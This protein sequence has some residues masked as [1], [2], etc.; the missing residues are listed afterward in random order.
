MKRNKY[1]SCCKEFKTLDQFHHNKSKKDGFTP[2]CKKC[3]GE[4]SKKWSDKNKDLKRKNNKK[5][6]LRNKEEV[7]NKSKQYRIENPISVLENNL[8]KHGLTI[9]E[10]NKLFQLQNGLCKI[11]KKPEIRKNQFN[12]K[13]CRLNVDHDHKTGKIRGLL[14]NACNTALGLL[15]DNIA[16]LNRAIRY[17]QC[18]K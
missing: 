9:L 18:K 17:L 12:K 4:Y 15:R 2:Y 5:W 3:N 16:N 6:Y 11:C 8:K 13:P 10:Y 1:C 7:K 14:C